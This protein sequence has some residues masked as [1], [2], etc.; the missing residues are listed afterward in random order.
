MSTEHRHILGAEFDY[1]G[2]VTAPCFAHKHRDEVPLDLHHVWPLGEGGPDVKSNL[3]RLCPNAHRQV[4]SYIRLLKKHNG[5][6]P[7]LK[8][9]FYGRWVRYVGQAGYDAITINE[10][11]HGSEKEADPQ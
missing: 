7:W 6:A 10:R 2:G 11:N 9:K 8:R 1:W 4:H 5:K 3:V